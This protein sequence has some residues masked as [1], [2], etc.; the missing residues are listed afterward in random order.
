MT[1]E[2][3]SRSALAPYA[4]KSILKETR[5]VVDEYMRPLAFFHKSA[6]SNVNEVN[7]AWIGCTSL[8][9]LHIAPNAICLIVL[10]K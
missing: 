7:Y 10:S 4:R 8:C 5:G 9:V 2:S 6:R 3:D 1:K